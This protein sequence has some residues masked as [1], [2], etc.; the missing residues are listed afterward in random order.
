M[1]DTKLNVYKKV[2]Q[3]VCEKFNGAEQYIKERIDEL[4]SE[5]KLSIDQVSYFFNE[6][7]QQFSRLFC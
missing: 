6:S 5:S 4:C 2:L 7:L 3:D 1:S